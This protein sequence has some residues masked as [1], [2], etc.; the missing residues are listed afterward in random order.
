M[1]IERAQLEKQRTIFE[2]QLA[3]HRQMAA[4]HERTA[5]QIEGGIAVCNHFLSLID[6]AEKTEADEAATAGQ[7]ASG[8]G[9]ES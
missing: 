9:G 1:T 7:S 2:R 3:E 6:R 5:A 8:G 4:Q